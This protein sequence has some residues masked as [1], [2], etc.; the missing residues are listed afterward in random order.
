MEASQSTNQP[1]YNKELAEAIAQQSI[2]DIQQDS[3]IF[4]DKSIAIADRIV[5]IMKAKKIKPSQL[6][7]AT[8]KSKAEVSRWLS[9]MHNFTVR[10]L[11][12]IEAALGE[13]VIVPTSSLNKQST[14]TTT[15][16]TFSEHSKAL[17][18]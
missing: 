16:A 13:D 15:R 14:P 4:V 8:G 5:M 10:T 7:E 11:A 12:K 2:A 3:V 1:A 9:G 17:K 18:G 6:A